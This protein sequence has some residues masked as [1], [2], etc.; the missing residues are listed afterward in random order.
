MCHTFPII[1]DDGEP[2]SKP[3]FDTLFIQHQQEVKAR[4]ESKLP[5]DYCGS[6]FGAESP[7]DLL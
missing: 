1:S 5:A 4:L 6:C 7:P 3:A 2:I